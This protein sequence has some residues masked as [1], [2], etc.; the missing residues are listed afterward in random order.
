MK[1]LRWL[2]SSDRVKRAFVEEGQKIVEGQD[3][4]R[5]RVNLR[6]QRDFGTKQRWNSGIEPGAG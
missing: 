5:R 2:A 1:L 4:N 6:D 3:I